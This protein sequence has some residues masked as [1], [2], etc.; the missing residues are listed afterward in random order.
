LLG[1]NGFNWVD[2]LTFSG[3]K[4]RARTVR[5][6]WTSNER[7]A[8]EHHFARFLLNRQVPGKAVIEA[9]QKQETVL[10]SRKWS[11]IKD[12]IRNKLSVQ[13]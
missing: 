13:T 8:V 5:K 10:A 6:P 2:C 9:T 4:T 12:F 3:R 1:F 11:T 7:R